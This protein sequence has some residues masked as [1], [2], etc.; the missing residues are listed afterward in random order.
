MDAEAI[1]ELT[2]RFGVA[3][4][5]AVVFVCK[6]KALETFSGANVPDLVKRV[7]KYNSGDAAHASIP[8]AAT[9]SHIQEEPLNEKLEKL[10]KKEKVMLFMKGS[11]DAPQCGFSRTAVQMLK[12]A[13]CENFGSFNILADPAVRQGLKEYSNWPTYPQLYVNGTLIGGLDIMKEL[14]EEG[15]L[16]STLAG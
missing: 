8:M 2:E 9:E 15:E 16:Q 6:G 7:N 1:P 14:A 10:I 3:A 5:P 13:G 12:D 4:V 11:P